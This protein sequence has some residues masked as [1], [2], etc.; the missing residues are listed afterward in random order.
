MLGIVVSR[1]GRSRNGRVRNGRSRIGR[2]RIGS[3]TIE[4][5]CHTNIGGF[6]LLPVER[7]KCNINRL[8]SKTRATPAAIT[9]QEE[10]HS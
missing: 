9:H 10:Q 2:S 6:L 3:N 7:G 5:C 1:N 8:K 4:R